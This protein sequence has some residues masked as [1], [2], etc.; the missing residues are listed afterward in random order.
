M[1]HSK[2]PQKKEEPEKKTTEDPTKES[3]VKQKDTSE[4]KQVEAKVS[5]QPVKTTKWRVENSWGDD[6][7]DKGYV[8]MSD[9][10]LVEASSGNTKFQA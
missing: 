8:M 9:E 5:L 10:W 4:T 6:K 3:E 2:E 7:G 1:C